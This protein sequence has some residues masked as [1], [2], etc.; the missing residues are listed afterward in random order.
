EGALVPRFLCWRFLEMVRCWLRSLLK[1][2]ARPAS[3]R[4]GK[5]LA[6]RRFSPE[7]EPLA[8]RVL[9][10]ILAVFTPGAQTLSVFAA[11]PNNTIAISRDA[12]GQTLIKRGT[13]PTAA[14]PP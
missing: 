7:L 6:A 12:A 4:G 11:S 14:A 9:P 1:T 5:K 2:M 3:R 10:A 8:D 13:L